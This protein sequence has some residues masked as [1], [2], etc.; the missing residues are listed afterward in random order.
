MSMS[1]DMRPVSG[2]SLGHD[3]EKNNYFNM[4]GIKE[5][6]EVE[7]TRESAADWWRINLFQEV[8]SIVLTRSVPGFV[9]VSCMASRPA[10]ACTRELKTPWH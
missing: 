1:Q 10:T 6:L 7:R 9:C 2:T 8:A 5:I 3:G 4:A